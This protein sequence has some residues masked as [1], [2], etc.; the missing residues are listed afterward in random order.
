MAIDATW[1]HQLR[2]TQWLWTID[3]N[4]WY[5]MAT[6]NEGQSM[7]IDR[8]WWQWMEPAEGRRGQRMNWWQ[9]RHCSQAHQSHHTF[10][11]IQLKSKCL[12]RWRPKDPKDLIPL[13]HEVPESKDSLLVGKVKQVKFRT[14]ALSLKNC[15]CILMRVRVKSLKRKAKVKIEKEGEKIEI[16]EKK[17]ESGGEYFNF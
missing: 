10:P 12:L 17:G 11:S 13:E 7:R 9:S 2:H 16:E 8:N 5:S 6:G 4:W 1:W 14:E 3:G 15:H